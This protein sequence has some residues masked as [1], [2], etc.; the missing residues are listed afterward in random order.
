MKVGYSRV[1]SEIYIFE[2][3]THHESINISIWMNYVC[4]HVGLDLFFIPK[5]NIQG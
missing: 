5:A 1:T 2:N 3:S 4:Q